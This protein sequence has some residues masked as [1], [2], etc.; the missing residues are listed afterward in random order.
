MLVICWS[1]NQLNCKS[2][3]CNITKEHLYSCRR[4]PY[5]QHQ[6]S[7]T[8]NTSS[9][10]QPTPVQPYS[11]HQFS[12]TANTS[13][14]TQP[15][16]VQPQGRHRSRYNQQFFIRPSFVESI[17]CFNNIWS[18]VQLSRGSMEVRTSIGASRANKRIR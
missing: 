11:Q 9:A 18:E 15:I 16:K 2:W 6:F 14:A 8:A 5:S 13:S 17:K 12:H 1:I 10:I 3:K 4:K 7:R